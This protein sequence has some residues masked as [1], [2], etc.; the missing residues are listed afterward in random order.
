MGSSAR[1]NLL[2]ALAHGLDTSRA[3]ALLDEIVGAEASSSTKTA[4]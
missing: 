2:W 3:I 1:A 4:R